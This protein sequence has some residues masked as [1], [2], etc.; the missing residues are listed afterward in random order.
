MSLQMLQ[1]KDRF[2]NVSFHVLQ[3]HS[4]LSQDK[5]FIRNSYGMQGFLV[6]LGHL[7][8]AWA[9]ALQV[10]LLGMVGRAVQDVGY[11]QPWPLT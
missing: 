2:Q 10:V 6:S 5:I 4:K 11:V 3:H 8:D 1:R 9:Q 7:Q